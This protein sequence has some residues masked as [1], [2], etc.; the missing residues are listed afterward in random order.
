MWNHIIN[1]YPREL[2]LTKCQKP[3]SLELINIKKNFKFFLKNEQ[4]TFFYLII[5]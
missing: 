4:F 3:K 1:I 5:F 2:L